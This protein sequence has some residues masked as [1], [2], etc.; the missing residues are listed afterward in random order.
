VCGFCIVDGVE[1]FTFGAPAHLSSHGG[2]TRSRC[3][4]RRWQS[5]LQFRP[6]GVLTGDH[7]VQR[8]RVYERFD[9]G[10]EQVAEVA[11]A[12]MPRRDGVFAAA[13]QQPV[14][15]AWTRQACS[16]LVSFEG[17]EGGERAPRILRSR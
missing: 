6:L 7:V 13:V 10:P 4:G 11:L 1:A 2:A 17:I 16:R 14:Q 8:G 12:T 15:Q 9:D 3:R 5:R